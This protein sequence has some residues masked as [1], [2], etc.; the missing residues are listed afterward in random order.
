ML[1]FDTLLS[2]YHVGMPSQNVESWS[3]DELIRDQ[4]VILVDLCCIATTRETAY[5]FSH[6]AR[7]KTLDIAM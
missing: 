1:V 3:I 6:S 4:P 5:E 7:T 2:L